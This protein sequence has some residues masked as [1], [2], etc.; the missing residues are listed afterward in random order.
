M[1]DETVPVA[2][3]PCAKE[4]IFK[5]LQEILENKSFDAAQ[6]TSKTIREEL[7]NIFGDEVQKYKSE[8]KEAISTFLQEKVAVVVE[9]AVKEDEEDADEEGDDEDDEE[10]DDDDDDEEEE[11]IDDHPD[12]AALPDEWKA[13]FESVVWAKTSKQYPWWPCLIYNPSAMNKKLMVKALKHLGKKHAVYNYDSND[14]DYALPT[15]IKPFLE[16]FEEFSAQTIPKRYQVSH[17]KG[18][19]LAKRECELPKED[20]ARWNHLE[21]KRSVKKKVAK[22]E[23]KAKAKAKAAPKVKQVKAPSK[24]VKEKKKSV[25]K[26][27]KQS[28]SSAPASEEKAISEEEESESEE[29]E[30]AGDESVSEEEFDFDDGDDE[31][32]EKEGDEY[33]EGKAKKSKKSSSKRKSS[34][35]DKDTEKSKKRPRSSGEKKEKSEKRSKKSDGE[36]E[37]ASKK[38]KK[39][40]LTDE[41]KEQRKREKKEKDRAKESQ[42]SKKKKDQP[43][44]KGQPLTAGQK[45]KLLDEKNALEKNR[46]SAMKSSSEPVWKQARALASSSSSSSAPARVSSTPATAPARPSSSSSSS[47]LQKTASHSSSSQPVETSVERARRLTQLIDKFIKIEE[48]KGAGHFDSSGVIKIMRKARNMDMSLAEWAESKFIEQVNTLRKYPHSTEVANEAKEIR[49]YLKNKMSTATVVPPPP[50]DGN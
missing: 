2:D 38:K 24:A 28:E 34:S 42:E 13:E 15:Q 16:N 1:S 6:M 49:S 17:A 5:K 43:A 32:E 31:G 20:R 4:E 48:Q 22:V 47:S 39:R 21:R 36:S 11:E 45:K 19:E 40:V 50:T 12:V 9:D 3:V 25:S 14:W 18:V 37:D 29:E 33:V 30:E 23:V 10:E 27:K 46:I 44:G 35:G 26:K 8:V 41:E 7:T